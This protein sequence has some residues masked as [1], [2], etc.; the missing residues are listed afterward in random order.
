VCATRSPGTKNCPRIEVLWSVECGRGPKPKF[1]EKNGML[2]TY[3]YDHASSPAPG[4][5]FNQTHFS[6]SKRCGCKS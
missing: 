1:Y 4:I 6:T 2:F 5:Y 3:P